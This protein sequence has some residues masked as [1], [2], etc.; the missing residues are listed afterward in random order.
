MPATV[1]SST[2]IDHL[3]FVVSRLE[4]G[5]AAVQT[6]LGVAPVFG[7]A[8]PGR[9]THNALLSIGP[10]T[11]LEVIAPDP[12][13][14]GSGPLPFGLDVPE[15][16]GRLGAFAV[17]CADIDGLVAE[18][19]A[20][21]VAGVGDPVAMSRVL[22]DGVELS[23]RLAMLGGSP[24][25]ARPFLISWDGAASPAHD[26][27]RAGRLVA[28]RAGLPEPR[29]PSELLAAL[30]IDVTVAPAPT[31]WLEATI[32]TDRGPVILG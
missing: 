12:A 15:L 26:S 21:G 3:V 7:G 29:P 19:R 24:Q 4:D 30:R 32:D 18:L 11:Y 2:W 22:P 27:P 13:Q 28:L 23:W 5:V 9:G 14:V 8:H 20:A 25:G 10:P 16:R 31:E 6:A 17:G 1:A